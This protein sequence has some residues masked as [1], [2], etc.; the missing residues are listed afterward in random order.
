MHFNKVLRSEIKEEIIRAEEKTDCEIVPMIIYSSNQYLDANYKMGVILSVVGT[1]SLY[2]SPYYF[3]NPANYIFVQIIFFIIGYLLGNIPQIKRKLISKKELNEEVEQKSYE[4][5]MHHNLHLTHNHNGV[6]IFVSLFE[7][8]IKI[9]CD[10]NVNDKISKEIW[11]NIIVEFI[12]T[13]QTKD[14]LI[15]LKSTIINVGNVLENHFPRTIE[16]SKSINE[17]E[18]DLIIELK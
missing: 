16:K 6:L 14:V 3:I 13:Y 18:D 8:K 17:L 1:I 4:A 11:Q 5:F 15:A 9:L 2:L 12:H 10:K 7:R